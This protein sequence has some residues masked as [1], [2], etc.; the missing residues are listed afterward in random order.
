[1]TMAQTTTKDQAAR[2]FLGKAVS[3]AIETELLAV[4]HYQRLSEIAPSAALRERALADAAEE[5]RHAHALERAARRDA[6]DFV[7]PTTWGPELD[8]LSAAFAA[9]ARDG[10]IAACLFVQDVLLEA[11]AINL[12][13]ALARTAAATGAFGLAAL[14]DKVIVPD[15]R[16]HLADGLR[17]ICRVTPDLAARQA[18]FERAAALLLPALQIFADPPRETGCAQTCGSC[19][20]RCLKLDACAADEAIGRGWASYLQTLASAR[21]SIGLT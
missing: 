20:D 19:R 14:L 2:R 21:R 16:M 1:M 5:A 18:A 15:E 3:K 11:A 7:A 6:L 4:S 17:E 12:Y 8:G 9:C 10:D 13:E